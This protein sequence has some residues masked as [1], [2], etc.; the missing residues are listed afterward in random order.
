MNK[1]GKGIKKVIHMSKH[2]LLISMKTN[3]LN[4]SSNQMNEKYHVFPT[5][6]ISEAEKW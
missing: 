3:E 5:Y 2:K 6:Y 1:W 4:H